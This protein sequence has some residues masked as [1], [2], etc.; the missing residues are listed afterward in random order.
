M[1]ARQYNE[2]TPVTSIIPHTVGY[3]KTDSRANVIE[4]AVC[5]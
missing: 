1:D 5:N 3:F 2:S 4:Y